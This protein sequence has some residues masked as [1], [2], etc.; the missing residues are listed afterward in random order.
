MTRYVFIV[1]LFHPLHPTDFDRRFRTLWAHI[2]MAG[3]EGSPQP[4]RSSNSDSLMAKK[5][6]KRS[7]PHSHRST[8]AN[9][10]PIPLIPTETRRLSLENPNSTPS[11]PAE[12]HNSVQTR[13]PQPERCR[14]GKALC[15]LTHDSFPSRFDFPQGKLK[16]DTPDVQ[17]V[18]I[19]V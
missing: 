18:R 11:G 5:Q 13:T 6:F 14:S 12:R 8:S 3:E 7:W 17:R 4:R 1:W 9:C 19:R 15:H 2:S 16:P 10:H